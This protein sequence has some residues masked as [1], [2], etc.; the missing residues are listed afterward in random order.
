M[1]EREGK[2]PPIL[3]LPRDGRTKEKAGARGCVLVGPPPG[4][5]P[6]QGEWPPVS[7][8]TAK[9]CP[10]P[11]GEGIQSKGQE[12]DLGRGGGWRRRSA[13][14]DQ[15]RTALFFCDTPQVHSPPR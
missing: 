3:P 12:R 5:C 8:R 4:V 9:G 7:Q 1:R 2:I 14:S 11:T 15:D 6:E 10:C 13:T